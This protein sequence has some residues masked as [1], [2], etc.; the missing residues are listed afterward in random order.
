MEEEEMQMQE[1]KPSFS[2]R[3]KGY[4]F[5]TEQ[6]EKETYDRKLFDSKIEKYLDH[7]ASE[8]IDE[9]GLITSID[10]KVYDERY[11]EIS[12]NVDGLMDFTQDADTDI[13][14]LEKR[15]ETLKSVTKQKKK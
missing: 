11:D 3:V 7:H 2:Q 15:V 5:K 1:E 9:Y 12:A 10:L 8:Y 6:G 4:L 13:T 14:N